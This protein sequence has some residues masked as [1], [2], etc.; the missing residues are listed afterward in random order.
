[1]KNLL[2]LIASLFANAMMIHYY[3]PVTENVLHWMQ[4]WNMFW[5]Y[6]F[7]WLVVFV[8]VMLPMYVLL[9]IEQALIRADY[10]AA[11]NLF[12][13]STILPLFTFVSMCVKNSIDIP[14]FVNLACMVLSAQMCKQAYIQSLQINPLKNYKEE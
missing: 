11:K 14:L 10:D 5:I 8:A 4:D 6:S 2:I 7:S 1:M 9:M 3:K 12:G 13:A